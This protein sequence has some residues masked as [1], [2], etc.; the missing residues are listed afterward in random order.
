MPEASKRVTVHPDFVDKVS[1]SEVLNE[2]VVTDGNIITG[3]GL[4]ATIPFAF[5]IINT[6]VS[7]DAVDKIK[8]DICFRA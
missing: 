2:P 7:G 1:T 6:L 3:Q 4:G 8:K 5:E